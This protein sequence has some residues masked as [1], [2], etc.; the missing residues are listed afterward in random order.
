M[1]TNYGTHLSNPT[2]RDPH[3]NRTETFERTVYRGSRSYSVPRPTSYTLTHP[4]CPTHS[5]V[6]DSMYSI[7]NRVCP[8]HGSQCIGHMGHSPL[9][10]HHVLMPR[11]MQCGDPY[12]DDITRTMSILIGGHIGYSEYTSVVRSSMLGKT[13]QQRST[14]RMLVD[15]SIRGVITPYIPN[16]HMAVTIPY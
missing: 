8:Y 5:V 2:I 12:P 13:G 10:C 1:T 3:N 16:G 4:M 9:D 11:T 6:A 14:A 7:D 15:G